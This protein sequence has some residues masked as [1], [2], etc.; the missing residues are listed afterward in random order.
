MTYDQTDSE[1]L[2]RAASTEREIQA[3]QYAIEQGEDRHEQIDVS[4][5]E[6]TTASKSSRENRSGAS[7]I[8]KQFEL[9]DLEG[10]LKM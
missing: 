4:V 1:R 9:E 3:L 7:C 10:S 5:L 6:K 8:C 2:A